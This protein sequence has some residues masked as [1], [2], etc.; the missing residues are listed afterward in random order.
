MPLLPTVGES[1]SLR[2][3]S[4]GLSRGTLLELILPKPIPIHSRG[5][6]LATAVSERPTEHMGIYARNQGS[7]A[8]TGSTLLALLATLKI[9]PTNGEGVPGK[10]IS[11]LVWSQACLACLGARL[12]AEELASRT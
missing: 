10:S 9:D 6:L 8:S 7:L 12:G 2:L 3:G 4:P 1:M 5:F 11:P